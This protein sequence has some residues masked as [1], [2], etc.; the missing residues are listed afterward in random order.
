MK[1]RF[2]SQKFLLILKNFFE[3]NVIIKYFFKDANRIFKLFIK[4]TI[5]YEK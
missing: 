1:S 4:N 2:F 3:S 5:F